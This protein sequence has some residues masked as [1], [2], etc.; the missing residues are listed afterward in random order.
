M[1]ERYGTYSVKVDNDTPTRLDGGLLAA[2][3][4]HLA[5]DAHGG[6]GEVLEVGGRDAGGGLGHL[7]LPFAELGCGVRWGG[8][9][10]RGVLV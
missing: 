8:P 1:S 3:L 9:D 10:L 4:A 7:S 2:Q 5:Q 6:V